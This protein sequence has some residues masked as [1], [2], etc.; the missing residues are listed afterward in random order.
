M[1]KSLRDTFALAL[2]MGLALGVLS[3]CFRYMPFMMPPSDFIVYMGILNW[4]RVA[5]NPFLVFTVFYFH[6][7]KLDLKAKLRSVM[8][9]LFLGLYVGNVLGSIVTFP[10]IM[11]SQKFQKFRFF[12]GTV[13]M[14]LFPTIIISPF[15][16]SLSA[17]AI[18][19]IRN[20]KT[21]I[22]GQKEN[23]K[24]VRQ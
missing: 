8:V 22:E 21:S 13:L 24:E 19:Y 1:D 14:S 9:L 4:V 6:G 15:F 16:V 5:V 7:R 11:H 2:L 18:A 10:V 20:I 3:G 12:L 23:K 17:S